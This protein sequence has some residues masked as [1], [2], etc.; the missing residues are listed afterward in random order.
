VNWLSPTHNPVVHVCSAEPDDRARTDLPRWWAS[1]VTGVA[2]GMGSPG[3]DG[4]GDRRS[5]A[6]LATVVDVVRRLD[7]LPLA[8]EL[9]AARLRVLAAEDLADRITDTIDLLDGPAGGAP[10][11]PVGGPAPARHASLRAALDWS[12]RPLPPPAA[13]LLRWLSVFPGSVPLAAVEW[14]TAGWLDRAGSIDALATLVDAALVE[15]EYGD[16][17]VTYR[18]LDP[19]RSFARHRLADTGESLAARDRHRVWRRLGHPVPH[20]RAVPAR[21]APGAAAPGPIMPATP[22]D[23]AV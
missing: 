15:P 22:A 20:P 5:V 19:V 13:R 21:P 17:A 10:Y 1:L 16:G 3:P 4:R 14:L 8:L 9:A 12:Y 7:G 2:L 11:R 18:L 6:D 23:L